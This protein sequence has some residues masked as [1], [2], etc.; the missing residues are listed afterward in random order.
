MSLTLFLLALAAAGDTRP[1]DDPALGSLLKPR[2]EQVVNPGKNNPVEYTYRLIE[3][4]VIRREIP[5]RRILDLGTAKDYGSFMNNIPGL[6]GCNVGGYVGE[7]IV[8]TRFSFDQP[9]LRGMIS[10][11]IL[12]KNQKLNGLPVLP[13]TQ[14]YSRPWYGLT[15]RPQA[16]DEMAT[17]V[18]DT[19]P[20]G[21]ANILMTVTNSP[22]EKTAIG[23]VAPT[24]G[25]CLAT[26]SKLNANRLALRSALAEALYHRTF[27]PAPQSPVFEAKA[28]EQH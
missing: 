2:Q 26:G 10:E 15:S 9:T 28:E 23:V 5:M 16:V 17:C 13:R 21:I 6:R 1:S 12:K 27:D 22:E 11:A 4:S 14:T 19:D 25:Q 18:A 3:C 20:M 24:L 7:N 8:E